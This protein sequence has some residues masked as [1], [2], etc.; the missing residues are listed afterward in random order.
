MLLVVPIWVAFASAT[1]ENI[2][3]LSEG[4][5]WVLG[6]KLLKNSNK[7]GQRALCS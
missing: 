1:H 5:K 3:I 4:M 2:T 6:D 7:E